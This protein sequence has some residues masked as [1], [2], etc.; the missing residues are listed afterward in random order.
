MDLSAQAHAVRVY[1]PNMEFSS[2][3]LEHEG[4]D[5]PSYPNRKLGT[6]WR[7]AAHA[8]SGRE[9]NVDESLKQASYR[10]WRPEHSAGTNVHDPDD[11][12]A[13]FSASPHRS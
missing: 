1:P 2:G 4:G 10:L 7:Q 3:S 12:V 6:Q 11:V 13:S 8:D 9:Y 5:A